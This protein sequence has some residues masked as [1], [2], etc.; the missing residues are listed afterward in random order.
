MS[1]PGWGAGPWGASPWGGGMGGGSFAVIGCFAP[2]EN[3]I[4]IL[5]TQVPYY[6]EILDKYDASDVSHYSIAPRPGTMG[7][8]GYDVRVVIPVQAI[9]SLEVPNAIDVYLDR[10]MSPYPAQ[11]TFSFTD[12]ASSGLSPIPDASFVVAGVYR[13]LQPQHE[14]LVM[15]TSDLANPQTLSSVQASGLGTAFP[16][17][18][19][20]GVFVVDDSGDYALETG[21]QTVKKRILR[22]GVTDKGAFA[23]LP[24]NYGVGLLSACKKLGIPSVRQK[25]AADYQSQILQEPEVTAC[26]VTALQDPSVPSLVHFVILAKTNIGTTLSFDHP[27]DIVKGV[28]MAQLSSTPVPG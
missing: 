13:K 23:H 4:R 18:V 16:S 9:I 25:Y 8:D 27:L 5:F 20:P 15:P 19:V 10:P 28:S 11:Y 2:A 22:R 26:T 3:I 1:F 14:D 6:S 7:Y 24:R 21:I 12:I 17:E